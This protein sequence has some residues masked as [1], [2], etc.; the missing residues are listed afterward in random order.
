MTR[1]LIVD[2][3][4]AYVRIYRFM[5]EEEGYSVDSVNDG[6]SAILT[7]QKTL[8]DLILLDIMI[9]K[10]NGFEVLKKLKQNN[11]TK[12]IPVILV[13]NLGVDKTDFDKGIALGAAEYLIKSSYTPKQVIDKVGKVLRN[14]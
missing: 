12:K 6:D 4:P 3:D 8:P 2:D 10:T 14:K 13:T 9:P 1:V 7:T 11:K 5:L